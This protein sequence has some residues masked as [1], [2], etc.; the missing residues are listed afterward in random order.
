MADDLSANLAALRI[1]RNKK[2]ERAHKPRSYGW[3]IGVVF[4]LAAAA[5]VAQAWPMLKSAIF[6]TEVETTVIA[7]VSPAQASVELTASGYVDAD[8]SSDI[9]PKVPGRVAAVHVR[10]GQKVKA[11]DVL[12]ELD[13]SD[14]RAAILAARGQVAAALAQAK[15]AEARVATA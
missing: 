4:A 8:R 12:V 13:P 1:D 5:G 9:A 11:G 6:K 10:Q 14:D 7:E 15:G 2:T 3:V